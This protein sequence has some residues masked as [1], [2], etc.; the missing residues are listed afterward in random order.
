LAFELKKEEN[1]EVEGVV[2]VTGG[3]VGRGGGPVL[4]RGDD[5][6]VFKGDGVGLDADDD[7]GCDLSFDL[8]S[9]RCTPGR[10]PCG[11]PR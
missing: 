4:A 8:T 2:G 6:C 1:E 5:C 10:S 9:S 7:S 11:C 3:R